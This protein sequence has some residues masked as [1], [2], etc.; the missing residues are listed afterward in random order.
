M[1][2]QKNISL[3]QSDNHTHAQTNTH[4]HTHSLLDID[5]Q[6]SRGASKAVAVKW[7]G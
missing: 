6:V 3:T 5:T 2:A 4:A 7:Q 1:H